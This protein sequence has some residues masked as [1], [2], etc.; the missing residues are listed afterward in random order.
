M[1]PQHHKAG[2]ALLPVLTMPDF[3]SIIAPFDWQDVIV[4]RW[5]D[6]MPGTLWMVLMALLLGIPC[7]LLGNYL[8]LRRM[9]LVGDAISHSVLP[10]LVLAFL[11]FHDL[12]TGPMLAGAMAAGLATTLLIEFITSKSRL[13][14]DAATG[15]TY[16]TLFALGIFLVVRYTERIHLDAECV[17]FGELEYVVFAEPSFLH[18]GSYGAVPLPILI[19]AGIALLVLAYIAAFYKELA[20][21]SFDPGLARSI[22]VRTGLIHYSLMAML[23]FVVV[24]SL[25]SVGILVVALLVLPGST[26]QFFSRRLWKLHLLAVLFSAT[27]TLCGFHLAAWF[28]CP[29]AAAIAIWGGAQF[30]LAWIASALPGIVRQWRPG[31]LAGFQTAASKPAD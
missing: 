24:T 20:L 9:A 30:A 4:D 21:T 3:A 13:K 11:I 15:I 8:L 17:L 27:A 19:S 1:N 5:T 23:S 31:G 25:E 22:G 29:T 18:W 26:A 2:T 28:K 16:T 10:G 14:S 6:Y 12:G 7:A